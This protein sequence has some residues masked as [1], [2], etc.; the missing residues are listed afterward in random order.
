MNNAF[1]SLILLSPR[2]PQMQSGD[3]ATAAVF[4]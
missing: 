3:D 4:Y 2:T 1:V